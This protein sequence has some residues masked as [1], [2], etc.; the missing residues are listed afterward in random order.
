[1]VSTAAFVLACVAT[2]AS[3]P[4]MSAHAQSNQ[5][6]SAAVWHL[7]YD[8]F[9]YTANR[10]VTAFLWLPER[11]PVVRG[12]ILSFM[13]LA[14]YRMAADPAIRAAAQQ[15]QLAI[16]YMYPGFVSVF[17]GPNGDAAIFESVLSNISVSSGHPE[18]RTAPLLPFG[19]STGAIFARNIAYYYPNRTVGV[20]YYKSGNIECPY[21]ASCDDNNTLARYS[22]PLCAVNGEFEEFGPSGPH[23][24]GESWE[25][26]W[27]TVRSTLWFMRTHGHLW[28]QIVDPGAGHRSWHDGVAQ[29]V[30]LWISKAAQY[31]IPALPC[32]NCSV[33]W[34]PA[35]AAG[36]G[37]IPLL[38]LSSTVGWLSDSNI[39][40]L[41]SMPL[42]WGQYRGNKTTA[43]W[44]FDNEL[45]AA[46]YAFQVGVNP[47]RSDQNVS[48]LFNDGLQNEEYVLPSS[49]IAEPDGSLANITA[50]SSAG[51][52]IARYWISQGSAAQ[53]GLS[54]F[55][56]QLNSNAWA[57]SDRSTGLSSSDYTVHVLAQTYG[58]SMYRAAEFSSYVRVSSNQGKAVSNSITF[59]PLPYGL[60]DA[61]PPVALNATASSGLPVSF[62]VLSGPATVN[63]SILTLQ[64]VPA[65]A[66][67]FDSLPLTVI[68]WQWGDQSTNTAAWVVQTAN[69]T[70]SA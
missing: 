16:L 38:N 13:I 4:S 15:Q 57:G 54:T 62:F 24:P 8:F 1:M 46:W 70:R 3:Y 29:Y 36:Q 60:T 58:D 66:G 49:L 64:P 43:W 20:I 33:P 22:I 44:H 30:A 67:T 32:T 27:L 6:N 34:Y 7:H 17:D 12:L 31:R 59:A 55:R 10:N 68:A 53:T 50:L 69:V 9:D 65:S 23:P 2:F 52:A 39:K 26:Q 21:W 11:A 51:T 19:H 63:G 18:L 41:V 45:A 14:E 40:P 61:S 35:Y 37:L 56:M 5:T 42:P 28:Q 47:Q 25:I 48:F